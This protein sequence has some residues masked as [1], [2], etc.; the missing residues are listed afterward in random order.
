M[1]ARENTA[2]PSHPV[3]LTTTAPPSSRGRVK[4]LDDN[5]F[6]GPRQAKDRAVAM[7]G[8]CTHR[9][10]STSSTRERLRQF[11]IPAK[12]AMGGDPTTFV[13]SQTAHTPPGVVPP[14][15]HLDARPQR[16][17]WAKNG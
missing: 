14:S 6:R 4:L 16:R 1:R 10:P 12:R 7:P 9:A 11:S 8:S 5:S 17:A 2:D 15:L 13:V 3:H